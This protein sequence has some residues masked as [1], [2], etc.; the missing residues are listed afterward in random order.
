MGK[1]SNLLKS[2]HGVILQRTF[3]GFPFWPTLTGSGVIS[4]PHPFSDLQSS[5]LKLKLRIYTTSFYVKCLKN[6]ITCDNAGGLGSP[7]RTKNL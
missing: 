5:T 7:V 2:L 4:P 1:K 3:A 6:F